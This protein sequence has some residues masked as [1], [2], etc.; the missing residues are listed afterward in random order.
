M[1]KTKL[2]AIKDLEC[3]YFDKP[4]LIFEEQLI[5]QKNA[6]NNPVFFENILHWHK[7][8]SLIIDNE[9]SSY[10]D[11]L[12]N[13]LIFLS[14]CMGKVEVGYARETSS[15][16]DKEN[17]LKDQFT[18]IKNSLENNKE[19]SGFFRD[20]FLKIAQDIDNIELRYT[21][22]LSSISR[23]YESSK[24]EFELYKNKFS[25][26][27]FKA[28]LD[29]ETE[30]Y[31]K[32]YQADL[33]SFLLNVGALPIQ[34]GVYIYLITKFETQVF[35]L[36]AVLTLIL[37]WSLFSLF[38]I[39]QILDNV[40]YIKGSV[41]IHF[42]SLIANSGLINDEIEPDKKLILKRFS[43]T[44]SM[45]MFYMVLVSI[46]SISILVMGFNLIM[47]LLCN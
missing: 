20:N 41:E 47:K 19:F 42:D 12:S 26:D 9:I 38:S 10:D 5:Y 24:R 31:L 43:K 11:E 35:P 3:D 13:R 29:K 6:S 30:S 7:F 2:D 1:Y 8:K 40:K 33:S 34:F 39:K 46:F 21:N 16:F 44:K 23:I 22:S 27:I 15:F 18:A 28:E 32:E 4:I 25:F 45:L 14:E 37:I 17:T 36:V